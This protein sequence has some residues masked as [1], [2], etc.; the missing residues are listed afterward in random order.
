MQPIIKCF[1]FLFLDPATAL[2][3]VHAP[4]LQLALCIAVTGPLARALL[5][6]LRRPT[7]PSARL[8]K[9]SYDPVFADVPGSRH[10]VIWS[11]DHQ[12]HHPAQLRVVKGHDDTFP[13]A[14]RICE[15]GVQRVSCNLSALIPVEADGHVDQIGDVRD[16]THN[17]PLI[18][19]HP[20]L[21]HIKIH[22]VLSVFFH[23]IYFSVGGSSWCHRENVKILETLVTNGEKFSKRVL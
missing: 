15:S 12:Q 9:G 10:P 22:G 2:D 13:H 19:L 1:D 20:I 6:V 18:V 16:S 11:W 8:V 17:N 7:T 14:I 3:F 4:M 21:N 5:E 23:W